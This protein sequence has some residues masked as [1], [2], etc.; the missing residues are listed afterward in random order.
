MSVGREFGVESLGSGESC[1]YVFSLSINLFWMI[2]R[3][4]CLNSILLCVVFANYR[5]L[6][7]NRLVAMKAR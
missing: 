7:R 6:S 5:F 1:L 3:F 2:Q 4:R